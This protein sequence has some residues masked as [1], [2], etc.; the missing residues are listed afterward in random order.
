MYSK[1]GCHCTHVCGKLLVPRRAHI[2][3]TKV[4]LGH[5]IKSL[6]VDQFH[7]PVLP[8]QFC[9]AQHCKYIVT[10]IYTSAMQSLHYYI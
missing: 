1:L 10:G 3:C 9:S 7:N 6:M 8:D 2:L 4:K 5:L